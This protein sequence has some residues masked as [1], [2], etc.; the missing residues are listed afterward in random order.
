MLLEEWPLQTRI[1]FLKMRLTL[2]GY[3]NNLLIAKLFEPKCNL[4]LLP[5]KDFKFYF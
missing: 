2:S 3:D 4:F 5:L 1:V